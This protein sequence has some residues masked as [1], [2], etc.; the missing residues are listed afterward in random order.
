MLRPD[1]HHDHVH[2]AQ[3]AFPLPDGLVR[4]NTQ[5]HG[6][7]GVEWLDRLPA[8]VADGERRWALS[9]FPP[10]ESLSYTYAA[11]AVRADGTA[12]VLK[13]CF[14]NRDFLAEAEALRL[15]G[16]RGAARLL[17]AD[18]DHGMLLLERLEPGAPLSRVEDDREA[19]SVAAGVMTQLWRPVPEDHS[20]PSVA[21]WAAGLTRLRT[22]FGDTTGPLPT[23]LVEQA[24][25][26]FS[27]LIASQ[28]EPVLLHG[29][30]HHDNILAA[31]RQPWLAIDP[32]GVV[33]EP[34]YET[35]ALLRNP[36]KLLGEPRPAEILA[37]RV[38]QLADR[39]GFD[40]QR[41]RGWGL[42]QAV[43]A[44]FWSIE[45]GGRLWE[46]PLICAELL[47][48]MMT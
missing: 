22:V 35:G 20:F 14:P 19:T 29:D 37:R 47:G 28:A 40:R 15:I 36:A 1:P 27:D 23:R 9:L 7:V 39:L 38:D 4:T 5:L 31:R 21:D 8:I 11:P 18:L 44:A 3:R 24:E 48:A 41:V 17:E 33:G 10:F 34:A 2:E 6:A 26:L 12:V 25:S 30:L 46:Q 16:G 45:D 42:A 43:L 32:K 13:A